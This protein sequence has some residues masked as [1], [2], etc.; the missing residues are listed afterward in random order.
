MFTIIRFI[1][2]LAGCLVVAY[3][4]MGYFGYEVNLEYF[5]ESK[6]LCRQELL[7]CQKDL[8]KTGVEGAKEKCHIECI[9]PELIIK[10]E[11]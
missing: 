9:D 8:L 2:W 3:F 4:V 10:R 11:K 1:I 5:Q 6:A 7:Q